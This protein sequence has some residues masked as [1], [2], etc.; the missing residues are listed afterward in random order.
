MGEKHESQV[1]EDLFYCFVD[2]EPEHPSVHVIP[3]KVVAEVI[4]LNHRIWLE[5]PGKKGQLHNQT[6]LRRLK[7]NSTGQ[8]PG[9]MN[10]YLENWSL[11]DRESRP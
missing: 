11:L 10:M 1:D 4:S 3:A 2:F 9:W 7:P 5:T 8:V 6:S